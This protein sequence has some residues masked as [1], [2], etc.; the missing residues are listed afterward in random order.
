MKRTLN[1]TKSSRARFTL[2]NESM[3]CYGDP[4]H[5][6]THEFSIAN[7]IDRGNGYQGYMSVTYALTKCAYFPEDAKIA[8][9]KELSPRY[10]KYLRDIGVIQ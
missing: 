3:G 2:I 6:A 1:K 7:G 4:G 10:E 5:Y 9:I 8:L